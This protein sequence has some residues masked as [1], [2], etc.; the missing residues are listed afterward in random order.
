MKRYW[1]KGIGLTIAAALPLTFALLQPQNPQQTPAEQAPMP[2]K[3]SGAERKAASAE[4]YISQRMF[5]LGY[6][7]QDAEIRAVE[8]MRTRMMP[9]LHAQQSLEKSSAASLVWKNHGPGNIGGRLRGV[10]VHP[11]NPNIIYVGS[12]SG[13]VWKSTDR[14]VSWFPTM[15]DLVTLNISALVMKPG[16]PNTLYAGTGEGYFLTDNLPGR[17]I[18]KTTD[19]GNTWR[20]VHI[21]QGLNSPFL[22]AIA[23]SPAD[24]NVVYAAGRQATPQRANIYPPV[25]VETIPDRGVNAIFKSID[26]GETW[27]DVTTGK[28]IEHNP[29][30]INDDFPADVVVSPNDANVVYAAFGLYGSGGIWKSINGGQTWSRLRSGL[31]DAALRNM[32]Y[33]RIKLAM[34]PSDP[35]VI[36]ASFTYDHKS[37]DTINLV[38][39]ATLGIW[40]TTDGGQF[41][42]Q[43][44]TPLT[45]NQHN[46]N[47]GNTTALGQQGN[48]AHAMIVHPADPNTVFVGGLDIYRT[49]DGGNTWAQVSM[50]LEPGDRLNPENLPYAHGDHH[51]FAFDLS[52]NPPTLYNGND[53]GIARSRD[54]G[55]TWGALN[56]DLGVTQFY[57]FAVHP[58]NP[59]IMMGGTQDTGTPMLL[60]GQDN[61]WHDVTGADG[62]QAYFDYTDP[63]RIYVAQQQ[64]TMYRATINYAVGGF[65]AS[66][67]IGY[68][69]GA[70]GITQRDAQ[71]A[72]FFPPYELSPN[73]P[74]VLIL[75]TNRV[76]QS[77]NRGD[78]WTPISTEFSSPLATV[79]IGVGNDSVIWAATYDAR[80]FKTTNNGTSWVQVTHPNLPTRFITDIEFDPSNINTV[81]LTYSGY[82]APHVFK[83]TDAGSS[84]KNITSNLPDIPANTIQVHPQQ[85][86]LLFLGTDIGVF[87]SDDGGQTWQ[88]STNGLPTVQVAAIVLN[89]NTNRVYAA[90]H[91]RGVYSAE[92]GNGENAELNVNVAELSLQ[93]QPGHTRSATFTISN[94]GNADLNY[95]I[96]ATGLSQ[97]NGANS[98]TTVSNFVN[99]KQHR[100]PKL[101]LATARTQPAKSMTPVLFSELASAQTSP[102]TPHAVTGTEVLVLDDADNRADTFLGFGSG[103][104]NGFLWANVFSSTRSDFRLESFDFYMRTELVVVD[105]LY[106]AVMDTKG[107]I[108]TESHAL[109]PAPI[110]NGGWYRIPLPEPL[111]FNADSGFS[112]AVGITDAVGFPAGTDVDA[113]IPKHSYYFD[114]GQGRYVPLQAV[115]GFENGAFLI[116]ANGSHVNHA[117]RLSASPDSGAIAAGESQTITVTFAAES[118]AEGNYYAQLRITSNGG[119]RTVPVAI[120][121]SNT[122]NV[123]DGHTELPL[124]L[125]LEQ[126]YPNPFNP[127]TRIRYALPDEGN[128]TLVVFDLNG[129]RVALLESGLK[130]AGRHLVRWNG[131]DGAGNRVPSG[132]YFYRLEATSPGGLATVLTKKLT[133]LK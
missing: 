107:H 69:G 112:I 67:N 95:N 133:L 58:T 125:Q 27:K 105:T 45:I 74:N 59:N 30:I 117:S 121:V 89:T 98:A 5:G 119:E 2:R 47:N 91:G 13:G 80:I 118:L 9:S 106:F 85:S 35:N 79:A 72:D 82:S 73:D 71:K 130:A 24:P 92:L 104:K 43:V 12:V 83:T 20:R 120:W 68:N 39:G 84:W 96:V 21:A 97:A 37:G 76:L 86:N 131:R 32:G 108:L 111:I 103:N 38:E 53:G 51:I 60:S 31:P 10:V 7:P 18:L 90:T 19:G 102:T 110:I 29:A 75:G 64:L 54:L 46:R 81:Y 100:F 116:R 15:N 128:V 16:D 122:V 126:N 93:L 99:A 123:E 48:Y 25:P 66:K 52:T 41:W 55:N 87:L 114:H 70:N 94:E 6:I 63:T 11:D 50:W 124:T 56:K 42:T 22:T 33:G 127:E 101:D 88:P 129:R 57:T 34:A 36:Y 4:R 8:D 65:T 78:S 77:Q 3:L 113:N 23:V 115:T 14:G 62:W 61:L 26:S 109:L 49:T 1:M 132:V 28:G 17:G 40:K 44:T